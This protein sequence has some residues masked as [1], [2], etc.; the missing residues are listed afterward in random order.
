M[1]KSNSQ[2]RTCTNQD[3][4]GIQTAGKEKGGGWESEGKHILV[5]STG[6]RVEMTTGDRKDSGPAGG[7]FQQ[8]RMLSRDGALP[9]HLRFVS[10]V[11]Q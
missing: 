7:T 3:S 6:G 4:A 1:N 2:G 8:K 5:G 10:E 9:G 11:W